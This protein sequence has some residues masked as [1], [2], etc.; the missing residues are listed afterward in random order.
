MLT[1]SAMMK[2]QLVTADP[3]EPVDQIA[4][5]MRDADVGAVIVITGESISGIFTERDLVNRLV[6]KGLDPAKTQVGDVATG[7]V[8]T[9]TANASLRECAE[10]LMTNQ[11]RHLPVVEGTR[12]IGILSARDF[13]EVAAREMERLV[14]HLRYDKQLREEEDP[15]DHLGGSYGR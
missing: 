12:P 6:A 3:G 4:R 14:E 15:Y 9:V 10:K 11:V 13:F 8:H 5:R 7:D 1:I 2:K